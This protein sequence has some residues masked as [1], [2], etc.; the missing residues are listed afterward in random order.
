MIVL[1]GQYYYVFY[2]DSCEVVC[3][4]SDTYTKTPE[5]CCLSEIGSLLSCL[6]VFSWII[7]NRNCPLDRIVDNFLLNNIYFYG[8]LPE[9]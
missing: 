7:F 5:R 9:M 3:L 2:A 6:P 4:Q 1:L 8:M